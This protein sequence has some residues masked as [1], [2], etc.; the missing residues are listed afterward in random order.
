MC[1]TTVFI[2]AKEHMEENISKF[3]EML[4]KETGKGVNT[5]IQSI[6]TMKEIDKYGNNI[7]RVTVEIVNEDI[8]ER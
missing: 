8:S 4:S 5:K 1:S 2:T 3:V 6:I 7:L